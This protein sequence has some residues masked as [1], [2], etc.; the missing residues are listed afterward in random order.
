[1][2]FLKLIMILTLILGGFSCSDKESDYPA[3]I[4]VLDGVKVVSN[5]DYPRDGHI[6]Y[7]FEEE[8]SIGGDVDDE[9]YIFHRPQD[10]KVAGDGTIFV[11]DWGNST[12]K[13]YNQEGQYIRT[14]GGR[15]QGPNEFGQLIYFSLGTDGNAYVMDSVGHR[16][17]ILDT[18]GE[19]LGGFRIEEG[20]LTDIATDLNNNIFLGLRLREE[21]YEWLTIRRYDPKGEGMVDYGEFELVQPKIKKVKTDYGISTTVSTSRVAATTV[22]KVNAEGMLYTAY[23]DSYQVSVY[24]M[25]ADLVL[26]FGR[27]YTPNSIKIGERSVSSQEVGVFNVVTRR[28]F[29]DEKNNVWIEFFRE[30]EPEE[31]VYDVFSPEGIYL[32][33]V[34]VPHRILQMFEGKAFSLVRDENDFVAAKRFRLVEKVN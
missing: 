27:E 19:Y 3:I 8:L 21:D 9:D 23:G 29:F 1:M 4:D 16:V 7:D 34:T 26:K 31:I 25:A 11:M 6:E 32:K 13:L 17:A 33:Q 15:G 30:Y 20:F 22:W 24:D 12:L 14:I 10:L 5:P 28:W 18:N 2:R